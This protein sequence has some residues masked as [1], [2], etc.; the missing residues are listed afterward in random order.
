MAPPHI[1]IDDNYNKPLISLPVYFD[2]DNIVE[3]KYFYN[4]REGGI[5]CFKELKSSENSEY[6]G[7]IELFYC[8]FNNE[9]A[10]DGVCDVADEYPDEFEAAEKALDA[11][12][13]EKEILIA[14]Y[15]F[16]DLEIL[17]ESI[18]KVAK[19]IKGASILAKYQRNGVTSFLYKYLLKKYGALVC[20]NYQTYKGH[21][22]W[23]LSISKLGIIRIYDLVKKQCISTFDQVGPC[24]VKSWSVPYNFPPEYEKFL[25]L[26]ACVYTDL[27]FHNIVLVTFV[28]DLFRIDNY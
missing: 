13:I 16:K 21:M 27:E 28:E 10:L 9:Y 26:D 18:L 11:F 17:H 5:F 1:L 22:L 24:S 3:S 6:S 8:E 19:Q 12:E 4:Q 15:T 20:D 14:R 23:V 7:C 2:Y 25:R